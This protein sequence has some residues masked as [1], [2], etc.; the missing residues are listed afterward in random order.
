MTTDKFENFDVEQKI[1]RYHFDEIRLI[2][3]ICAS[4]LANYSEDVLISF[5]ESIEGRIEVLFKPEF[6]HSMSD[7]INIDNDIILD[8]QKLGNYLT[9]LYSSQW[10]N[11]MSDQNTS[12]LKV[13]LL[14]LDI[15]QKLAL[16]FIEP[17]SFLNN[18]LDIDWT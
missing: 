11:K 2:L 14:S 18:N 13:R 5:V 15:L 3:F 8:F 7:F 10:H 16:E 9:N 6:L 1:R 17:S 12:W 4:N